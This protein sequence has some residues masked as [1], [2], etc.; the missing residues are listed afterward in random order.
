MPDAVGHVPSATMNSTR[1]VLAFSL[2]CA[3]PFALAGCE[4]KE[5]PTPAA[6]ATAA[7]AAPT[8]PSGS[9]LAGNICKAT[10]Q[11]RVATLT[12][13]G[14]V[15]DSGPLLTVKNSTSVG[16]KNGT[17]SLWFYDKTGKRLDVAGTKHYQ[18]NGDIFA[19]PLAAGAQKSTTFNF[20]KANIPTG[21]AEIEGEIV[22]ATLQKA[23]GTDGPTWKNDDLDI[24]ERA[25]AGT[26]PPNAVAA[27][28]AA[29]PT[30]PAAP[31]GA[32]VAA[33]TAP[34]AKPTS[35]PTTARPGVPGAPAR[36]H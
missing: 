21:T 35:A 28:T 14:N 11:N 6:S 12:W 33:K 23:D 32:A 29:A 25:M 17:V 8:C 36:G 22:S 15:N 7:P 26:P 3:L 4:Q 5:A 10:G 16:L 24:E 27:A 1:T 20:A 18:F 31:T 13:S 34:T 2:A 30:G 9:S 19:G